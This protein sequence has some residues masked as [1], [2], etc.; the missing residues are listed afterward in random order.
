[1]LQVFRAQRLAPLFMEGAFDADAVTRHF[2][3]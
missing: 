1:L 2:L 3:A